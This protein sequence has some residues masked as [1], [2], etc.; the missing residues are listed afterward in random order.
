VS[1]TTKLNISAPDDGEFFGKLLSDYIAGGRVGIVLNS[2]DPALGRALDPGPF[3]NMHAKLL[4]PKLPPLQLPLDDVITELRRQTYHLMRAAGNRQLSLTEIWASLDPIIWSVTQP[5]TAKLTSI[6]L[7]NFMSPTIDPFDPAS[8]SLTCMLLSNVLISMSNTFVI[9]LEMPELSLGVVTATAQEA[10]KSPGPKPWS[11]AVLLPFAYHSEYA[12]S[13]TNMVRLTL[14][15]TSSALDVV[16]RLMFARTNTTF[17]L[18]GTASQDRRLISRLTQYLVVQMTLGFN[19]S[20][21]GSNTRAPPRSSMEKLRLDARVTTS[22]TM[23]TVD[24]SALVPPS[25]NPLLFAVKMG[26]VRLS[27]IHDE[28]E[29]AQIMM[30]PFAIDH[31]SVG[32]AAVRINMGM[33]GV[34]TCA[35]AFRKLQNKRDV[36]LELRGSIRD[37][38]YSGVVNTTL[39]IPGDALSKFDV[40]DG[41]GAIRLDAETFARGNSFFQLLNL[42][43]I[44]GDT[45]GSTVKLPCVLKGWCDRPASDLA[46]IPIKLLAQL[47]FDLE[48]LVPDIVEATVSLPAVTLALN[49][50]NTSSLLGYATLQPLT[51]STS[52]DKP[53]D[54]HLDVSVV[55][56]PGLQATAFKLFEKDLEVGLRVSGNDVLSRLLAL[57]P[58]A[59]TLKAP[60]KPVTTLRTLP[61]VC[62]KTWTLL[63]TDKSSMTASV[64]LPP[65]SLPIPLT[66]EDME[67]TIFYKGVPIL[68]AYPPDGRLSIGPNGGPPS[69]NVVTLVDPTATA[70]ATCWYKSAHPELC[71][72]G[73]ALGKIL[74]FGDGGEML[75][76]AVVSFRSPL[77]G[78]QKVRTWVSLYGPKFQRPPVQPRAKGAPLTCTSPAEMV[79]DMEIQAG[80]TVKSSL[81]VWKG[82][83]VVMKMQLINMF[84]FPIDIQR[85]RMNLYFKDPD[86]VP[87]E[88]RKHIPDSLRFAPTWDY[89][90]LWHADVETPGW[91]IPP[92]EP[93]WSPLISPGLDTSKLTETLARLYDEVVEHER[94]CAD[95]IDSVLGLRIM[96]DG[97]E[98]FELDMLMTIRNIPCFRPDACVM[99]FR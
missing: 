20:R 50:T 47:V 3:L 97:F 54:A 84:V 83:N 86:G 7:L 81:R 96:K 43:V 80:D 14:T 52:P 9:D 37:E 61:T 21:D 85:M 76:D 30:D 12:N 82:V 63:A 6:Q 15:N 62:D 68:R 57:V 33:A 17:T 98:P 40:W 93:R 10:V 59:V 99:A 5:I 39:L 71:R 64:K 51:A 48:S 8:T 55:D 58:F 23:L 4:L 77:G 25:A 88:D 90:L 91:V 73:E 69:L 75:A 32:R 22:S 66:L 28:Q 36:R 11:Y 46:P 78:V 1:V 53:L 60:A 18:V 42:G 44:G 26:A 95:L 74:A 13:S 31:L 56:I 16:E 35:N 87:S 19:D 65:L 24:A 92:G 79:S 89:S 41:S 38:Y 72:L 67:A 94:M 27:M 34:A 45:V 2:K 29:V 49:V 70:G